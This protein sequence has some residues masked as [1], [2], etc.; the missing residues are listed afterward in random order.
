M[1]L[2]V[3]AAVMSHLQACASTSFDRLYYNVCISWFLFEVG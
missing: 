2:H 1:K 3:S